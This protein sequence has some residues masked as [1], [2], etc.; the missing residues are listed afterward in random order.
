MLLYESPAGILMLQL[1]ADGRRLAV[2]DWLTSYPAGFLPERSE[3]CIRLRHYAS[4][5]DRYFDGDFEAVVNADLAPGNATAFRMQIWKHLRIIPAGHTLTYGKL[6]LIA[7]GNP[8]AARPA[9]AACA[10]NRISI[11]IPC[12]RVVRPSSEGNYRGGSEAKQFLLSFEA[13]LT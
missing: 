9:G 11:F 10:A 1:A 4:L 8:H 7:T 13:T 2:C 6:A 3:S 12:H 5:L